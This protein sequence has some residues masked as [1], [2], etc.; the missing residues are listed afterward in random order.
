MA[1]FI[2]VTRRLQVRGGVDPSSKKDLGTL[3]VAGTLYV[4]LVKD[5]AEAMFGGWGVPPF[6]YPR[7]NA[8]LLFLRPGDVPFMESID[9]DGDRT[10]LKE[11]RLRGFQRKKGEKS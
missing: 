3:V 7:A 9:V 2:L 6:T 10:A 11:P 5:V 4:V 1:R 8:S